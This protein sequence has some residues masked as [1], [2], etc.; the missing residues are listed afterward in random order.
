MTIENNVRRKLSIAKV[1]KNR[2]TATTTK[3]TRTPLVIPPTIKPSN[4]AQFGIG[5]IIISSMA[6]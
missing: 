6:F 1:V 4:I 2:L 3:P 5:E